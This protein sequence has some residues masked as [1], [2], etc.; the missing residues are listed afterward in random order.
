MMLLSLW[1][2]KMFVWDCFGRC[3]VCQYP[4]EASLELWPKAYIAGWSALMQLL[5]VWKE[6]S[7]DVGFCLIGPWESVDRR[8]RA[9]W[10]FCDASKLGA[11][12]DSPKPVQSSKSS[13][14]YGE[15]NTTARIILVWP[16]DSKSYWSSTLWLFCLWP[17]HIW[18]ILWNH[19][20]I[21]LHSPISN[22][23]NVK[24]LNHLGGFMGKKQI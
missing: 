7:C 12:R 15:G 3:S 5:F 21:N 20:C 1:G 18:Q 16:S 19:A 2:F 13:H 23:A 4:D 6:R 17:V 9:R 22:S 8:E 24:L 11:T 10:I 14:S